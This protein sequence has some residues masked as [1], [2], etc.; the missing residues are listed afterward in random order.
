MQIS[1]LVI[2][3][4]IDYDAIFFSSLTFLIIFTFYF[5]EFASNCIFF[6]PGWF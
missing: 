1:L 6:S 5:F 4:C 2:T 3:P